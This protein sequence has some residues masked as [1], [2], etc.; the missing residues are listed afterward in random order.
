MSAGSPWPVVWMLTAASSRSP[1]LASSS[2]IRVGGVLVLEQVGALQA[3]LERVDDGHGGA[4]LA[5][6]SVDLAGR[7]SMPG[8]AG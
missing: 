7:V 1:A 8:Q 5:L 6:S 4:R 3:L 2:P